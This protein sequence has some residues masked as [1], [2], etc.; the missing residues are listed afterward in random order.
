MVGGGEEGTSTTDPGT[1]I[2]SI[3][4]QKVRGFILE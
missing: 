4:N 2:T 1:I 3:L